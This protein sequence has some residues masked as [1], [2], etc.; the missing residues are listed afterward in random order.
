MGNIQEG[1]VVWANE[2]RISDTSNELPGLYLKKYNL[3][4]NRTNSAE[5]VGKPGIY[6]DDVAELTFA[7]YLFRLR[8]SIRWM[9]PRSLNA[10]MTP[11][12]DRKT[13]RLNSSHS[14]A[15]SITSSA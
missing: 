15:S 7:S 13:P 2:K 4:Y 12:L 5:L 10:W 1:K 3:L 8:T 14:C 9:N 11:Y 6:L